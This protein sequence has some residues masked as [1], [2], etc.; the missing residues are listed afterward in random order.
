MGNN[1]FNQISYVVNS[2]DA[3]ISIWSICNRPYPKKFLC[4]ALCLKIKISLECKFISKLTVIRH[5]KADILLKITL[6]QP[7]ASVKPVT[8]L[9]EKLGS[10]SL[11]GISLLFELL[12]EIVLFILLKLQFFGKQLTIIQSWTLS[13][14]YTT[15]T[16]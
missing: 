4:E 8:Q 5:F 9:G 11:F 10:L 1:Y 2:I 15:Q 6:K 3:N 16:T 7:S 14:F 12:L 13:S